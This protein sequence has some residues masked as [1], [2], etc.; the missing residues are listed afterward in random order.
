MTNGVFI[1]VNSRNAAFPHQMACTTNTKFYN[2]YIDSV[3]MTYNY[4]IGTIYFK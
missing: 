4:D 1:S 3:F 2:L